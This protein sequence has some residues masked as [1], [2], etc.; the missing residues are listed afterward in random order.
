MW[1]W[2]WCETGNAYVGCCNISWDSLGDLWKYHLF[3]GSE[4]KTFLNLVWVFSFPPLNHEHLSC[5]NHLKC[6][7]AVQ[8]FG[9]GCEKSSPFKIP[10]SK[11]NLLTIYVHMY[12]E[13]EHKD[14][15]R[16]DRFVKPAMVYSRAGCSNTLPVQCY[17]SASIL[18]EFYTW[19]AHWSWVLFRLHTSLFHLITVDAVD[20]HQWFLELKKN[21]NFCS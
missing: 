20:S 14:G 4:E 1:F 13:E 16:I 2:L 6:H 8:S 5:I 21:P 18:N 11:L 15:V 3:H 7:F 9:C 17:M 19:P 10:N 12:K